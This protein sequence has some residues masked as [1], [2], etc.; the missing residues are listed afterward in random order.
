MSLLD[1]L[2]GMV[3]MWAYGWGRERKHSTAL[4]ARHVDNLFTLV[5]FCS[6]EESGTEAFLQHVFDRKFR[7]GSLGGGRR[8]GMSFFALL[9]VSSCNALSTFSCRANSRLMHLA[10]VPTLDT[11]DMSRATRARGSLLERGARDERQ[12]RSGS[13]HFH[14]EPRQ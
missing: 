4:S 5:P 13:L 6:A 7:T 1:T 12:L 10:L 14:T 8:G 11:G 9:C 2:D 3:M